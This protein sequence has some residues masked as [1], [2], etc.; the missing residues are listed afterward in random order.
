MCLNNLSQ[1]KDSRTTPTSHESRRSWRRSSSKSRMTKQE[2]HTTSL[3]SFGWWQRTQRA[4]ARH[5]SNPQEWEL[6]TRQSTTIPRLSSVRARKPRIKQSAPTAVPTR[7]RSERLRSSSLPSSKT[8]GCGN[9]ETRRRYILTSRQRH[10]LPTSKRG[11]QDG[12]P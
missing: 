11:A 12:M 5:S 9:S 8:H 6:T 7:R 1:Y 2:A 4:T 10:C 3:A